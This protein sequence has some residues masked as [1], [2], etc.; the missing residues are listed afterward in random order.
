L[1]NRIEDVKRIFDV[2]RGSDDR[3]ETVID[4]PDGTIYPKNR[5]KIRVG[6]VKEYMNHPAI[7]PEIRE[8]LEKVIQM[9]KKIS[10]EV[11]EMDLPMLDETVIPAYY[12][13]ACAEA[14]SN[15]ARYDGVRYGKRYKEFSEDIDDLVCGSRT[16]FGPEVRLR[17]LLGTFILRA[18]HYE[19]FYGRAQTAR[20]QIAQ[21][22]H[23]A[24]KEVDFLLTPTAPTLPFKIGEFE[25]DPLAMKL[26]DLFTVTANLAGL[27][28]ISIPVDLVDG[29]PSAVQ[30]MAARLEDFA[31]LNFS[32]KLASKISFDL[33][34]LPYAD[35]EPKISFFNKDT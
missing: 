20:M 10:V 28:A 22:L 33:S 14:S 18:G 4:L 24:F 16:L 17:V 5:Q 1:G 3:D 27:P 11:V 12:L 26:A 15:L 23:K 6:L 21:G 35:K 32:E 34:R 29:L 9:L 25:E 19:Q 2:I 13:T 31:L 30:L 7:S 8:T